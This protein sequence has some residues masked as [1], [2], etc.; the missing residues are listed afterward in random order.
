MFGNFNK[1]LLKAT[2]NCREDMHEPDEQG[3]SAV[4]AGNH[5]D[6]AMGDDPADNCGEFTVAIVQDDGSKEWFNLAT[7]I[8][9]ARIGAGR[10]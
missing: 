2:E 1:R 9:L 3:I 6:N 4:V 8:A 5:L 10:K 7:L